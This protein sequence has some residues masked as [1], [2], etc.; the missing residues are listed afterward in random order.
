MQYFIIN[1]LTKEGKKFRPSDWA[2]RLAGV[3]SCFTPDP[4]VVGRQIAYSEY[5]T[6]NV[7]D[8]ISCVVIENKLRDVSP[9]AWKFIVD[10]AESNS[11]QT[12]ETD[13]KP[14]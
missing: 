7:I 9:L 12:Y 8:G 3:L 5:V 1:G 14:D 2:Q 13:V 6:P 11:L 4:T 10:F